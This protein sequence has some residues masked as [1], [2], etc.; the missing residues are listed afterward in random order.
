MRR[1]PS[2][3]SGIAS[4]RPWRLIYQ[5]AMIRCLA[6]VHSERGSETIFEN[7]DER[8]DFAVRH[9]LVKSGAERL[10]HCQWANVA[11][12]QFE[13]AR[14]VRY[15]RACPI[16][17]L[18]MK[19]RYP[20]SHELNAEPA[21]RRLSIRSLM[22][23]ILVSAVGLAALSEGRRPFVGHATAGC[24]GGCRPAVLARSFLVTGSG[25]GGLGSR[26]LAA[27]PLLA[28]APWLSD[29]FQSQLGTTHLLNEI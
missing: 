24:A 2:R 23:F 19:G 29:T 8:F 28:F 20:L 3:I 15:L 16:G 7:S 25:T 13:R 21:M 18:E 11:R 22:A 5:R 12:T 6:C 10:S 4:S 17:T 14:F 27:R 26:S 1:I 9:G